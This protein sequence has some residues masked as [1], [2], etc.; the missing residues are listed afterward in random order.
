MDAAVIF[1]R[2][3]RRARVDRRVR[4]TKPHFASCLRRKT[5][6]SQFRRFG[7]RRFT[8]PEA[9]R[10]DCILG[11]VSN[12]FCVESTIVKEK[13]KA[14]ANPISDQVGTK[15]LSSADFVNSTKSWL[16]PSLRKSD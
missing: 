4:V 8:R 6:S 10:A 1:S 12:A 7:A 3:L 9:R 5:L 11:P 16:R 15:G 2:H 14:L 13:L